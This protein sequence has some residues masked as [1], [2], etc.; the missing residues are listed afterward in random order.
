MIF[1]LMKTECGKG[2]GTGNSDEFV[3]KTESVIFVIRTIEY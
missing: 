3:L 1:K 2:S